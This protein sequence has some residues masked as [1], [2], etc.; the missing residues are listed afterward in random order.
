MPVTKTA[1]RALRGSSKKEKVNTLILSKLGKALRSAKKT[2]TKKNI[3]TAI[4]LA[5]KAA[6]K[7]TIHKNKAARIK[8]QLSKLLK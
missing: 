1:K 2:K 5:D 3:E 4:S 7:N 6:K 8:S